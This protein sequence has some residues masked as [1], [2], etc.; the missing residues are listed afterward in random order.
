MVKRG[1]LI[2]QVSPFTLSVLSV[3][4]LTLQC[5]LV[6]AKWEG[7]KG[8]PIFLGLFFF[9]SFFFFFAPF[10]VAFA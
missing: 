1:L 8:G 2:W 4:N 5:G 10:P 7:K 3:L 9:L 6:L